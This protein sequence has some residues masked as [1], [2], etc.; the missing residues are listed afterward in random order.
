LVAT[1][2]DANESY[3][4]TSNGS[5]YTTNSSAGIASISGGSGWANLTEDSTAATAGSWKAATASTRAV[6]DWAIQLVALAPVS[7]QSATAD[8]GG[9]YTFSNLNNGS[10]TVTPSNS[11]HTFTPS[12]QSVTVNNANVTGIN[13]TVN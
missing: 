7:L 11:G 5:G 1:G 6:T 3:L 2:W 9:N 12:S 13:F 4:S 8:A 10:Y